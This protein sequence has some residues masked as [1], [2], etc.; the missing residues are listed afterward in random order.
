[1]SHDERVMTLLP[2]WRNALRTS[3]K[4]LFLLLKFDNS[5]TCEQ[6]QGD[7]S[8]S[9]EYGVLTSVP[10]KAEYPIDPLN[11]V[12]LLSK[13]AISTISHKILQTNS[14]FHVNSALREGFNCYFSEFF[15]QYQKIFYFC[16]RTGHQALILQNLYT[17]LIFPNF[18]R[19]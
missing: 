19:S 9:H 7:L 6:R 15:C 11:E 18:L 13:F 2:Q 12:Y 4:K 17:F 8:N 10:P 16:W 14:T 5:S 3:V 1:M